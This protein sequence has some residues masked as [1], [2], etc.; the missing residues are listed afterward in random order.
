[1]IEINVLQHIYTHVEKNQSPLHEKGFQ[2]LLYTQQGLSE[3]DIRI[4]ER[5]AFYSIQENTPLRRQSYPLDAMRWVISQMLPLP[6]PDALGRGGRYLA[7]SLILSQDDWRKLGHN[8]FQIF[9]MQPFITRVENALAKMDQVPGNIARLS[10][11][12]EPSDELRALQKLT[13]GWS[14]GSLVNLANLGMRAKELLASHKALACQMP[15]AQL[16]A[17]IE[18]AILLTPRTAR[19]AC[20]F[21][22]YF[23]GCDPERTPIWLAG[24]DTNPGSEFV[25][26]KAGPQEVSSVLP[27]RVD[28]LFERWWLSCIQHLDWQELTSNQELVM[29]LEKFLSDYASASDKTQL[30]QADPKRFAFFNSLHQS[31]IERKLQEKLSALLS[32]ALAN[33][34]MPLYRADPGAAWPA[35]LNSPD[36]AQMADVVYK[37]LLHQVKIPDD[38]IQGVQKLVTQTRHKGLVFLLAFWQRGRDQQTWRTQLE[39]LPTSEYQSYLKEMSGAPGFSAFDCWS[40]RQA[41]LW[42]QLFGTALFKEDPLR[43]VKHLVSEQSGAN[44]EHLIDPIGK[45]PVA[46]QQD[47]KKVL[48]PTSRLAPRLWQQLAQLPE[49]PSIWNIFKK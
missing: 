49:K 43:L 20:S 47:I 10:L 27:Q 44:L 19:G 12:V 31:V 1:M 22:T 21:D 28:T 40:N 11:R 4:L 37:A 33:L 7:H 3:E 42:M 48:Q 14:A 13:K 29:V 45:L 46:V 9:A 34:V 18:L 8:P 16:L 30:S 35:L 36:Y 2:T 38:Q 23:H 17:V 25:S 24:F 32:P 39:N 5:R 6:E 15:P 26:I 41:A